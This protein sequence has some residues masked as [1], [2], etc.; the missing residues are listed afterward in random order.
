MIDKR[1]FRE[2]QFARHAQ[3]LGFG[4]AFLEGNALLGVIAF[5]AFQLFEEIQVPEGAAKFAIRNSLESDGLFLGDQI[6]NAAV[7]D[8]LQFLGRNSAFFPFGAGFLQFLRA[9]QTADL[10]GTKGGQTT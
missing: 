7:L 5:D 6:L 1:V 4:L 3:A 10:I 9:K 8:G 2:I